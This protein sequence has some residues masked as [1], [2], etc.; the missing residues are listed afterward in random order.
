[1]KM[2]H[3]WTVFWIQMIN[4]FFAASV[5]I[6]SSIHPISWRD[7]IWTELS[8]YS[9]FRIWYLV[10]DHFHTCLFASDSETALHLNEPNENSYF[11]FDRS[12]KKMYKLT[13]VVENERNWNYLCIASLLPNTWIIVAPT[14]WPKW[15]NFSQWWKLINNNIKSY[16]LQ[17]IVAYLQLILSA[18]WIEVCVY[19]RNG[20]Y[21]RPTLNPLGLHGFQHFPINSFLIMIVH[22]LGW[23]QFGQVEFLHRF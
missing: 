5:Q 17:A 22:H 18:L 11:S 9:N 7:S 14:N 12:R 21:D 23:V 15:C 1:M 16:L 4:W 20:Q 2:K 3:N 8:V 6:Y 10:F 13:A 19:L